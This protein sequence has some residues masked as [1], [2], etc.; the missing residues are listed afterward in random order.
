VVAL[1]KRRPEVART[2]MREALGPVRLPEA[3]PAAQAARA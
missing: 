1:L 2:L 3:D